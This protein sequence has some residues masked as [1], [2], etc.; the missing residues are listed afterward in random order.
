MFILWAKSKLFFIRFKKW[1]SSYYDD[2]FKGLIRKIHKKKVTKLGS[3]KL[4]IYPKVTKMG[5]I[6]GH[7]ID[8]NGVG[9]E[10]SDTYP[11]K[12]NPSTP[13]PVFETETYDSMATNDTS[14]DG[15]KL[16]QLRDS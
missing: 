13:S 3:Q 16:R 5:S 6:I 4:N 7:R 15:L 11:A 2:L 1:V 8:F 10:A 12:I 14:K 9:A